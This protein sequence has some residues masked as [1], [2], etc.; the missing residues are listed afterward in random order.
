MVSYIMEEG[1]CIGSKWLKI[2]IQNFFFFFGCTVW[3]VGPEVP[4]PGIEPVPAAV[5]AREVPEYIFNL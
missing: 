5:E 2:S 4:W 1:I 3:H